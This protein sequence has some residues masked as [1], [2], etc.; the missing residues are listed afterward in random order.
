MSIRRFL[1]LLSTSLVVGCGGSPVLQSTDSQA[2]RGSA[3]GIDD[4]DLGGRIGSMTQQR[5]RLQAEAIGSH[6]GMLVFRAVPGRL[7]QRTTDADTLN[8]TG[9][10]EYHGLAGT[11]LPGAHA[12][13][14]LLIEGREVAQTLTQAD[15]SWSLSVARDRANGK[16]ATVQIRLANPRWNVVKYSWQGAEIPSLSQD[17]DTGV[18][19]LEKGSTNAQAAWIHEIYLRAIA[20]FE[21]EGIEL[22]WWNRQL[23]TN[24]PSN[25]NYFSWGSVHLTNA[26]WWDVNGHEIGH[27][28]HYLGINGKMGGGQHKIDEC[29]SSNLAWSEGFASFFGAAISIDRADPDARFQYMV[30]RRSPIRIENVPADVCAGPTNEWWTGAALWDLY[31]THADGDDQVALEF[32]TIWYALAKGNGQKAVGSMVDAHRLIAQKVDPAQHAAIKRAMA[33]NTMAVEA[34][35]YH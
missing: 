14:A 12:T 23:E 26:E 16:K 30:P 34:L 31:D 7:R 19:R 8:V 20:L 10:F 15:G 21:R 1:L 3:S 11:V 35:A 17:T 27:A 5:N 13:V 33:Q 32:K 6:A 18:A 9:K 24:W 29:Y 28:L 4:Q 25:G 2:L 22:A